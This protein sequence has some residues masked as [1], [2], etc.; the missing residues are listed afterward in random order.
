MVLVGSLDLFVL[1]VEYTTGSILLSLFVWALV[2]LI[3]GILGRMSM[4]SILVILITFLSVAMVGYAGAIGSVPVFLFAGW[5]LMSGFVN[6]IN[7]MR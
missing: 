2:L 1:L 4:T 3:T 7:Q 6:W 5:Y